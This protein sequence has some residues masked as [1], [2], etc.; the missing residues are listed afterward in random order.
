MAAPDPDVACSAFHSEIVNASFDIVWGLLVEKVRIPTKHVPGV[1]AVTI[2]KD[3][4]QGVERRMVHAVKGEIHE[5]ITY[6]SDVD[7]TT[8]RRK[9]LVTF[10][11]LSDPL[12][13]GDVLNKAHELDDGRTEVAYVMRWRFQQQIT[14]EAR[15][16]PFP[17]GGAGAIAGAVRHMKAGAQ[18][19]ASAAAAATTTAS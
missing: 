3:D 14:M 19:A 18:A 15:K 10:K 8:G 16:L 17:D 12:L 6:S 5:L 7:P 9:G 1:L 2:E 11:M 13:E 4:D